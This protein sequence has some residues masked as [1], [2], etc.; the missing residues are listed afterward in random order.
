MTACAESVRLIWNVQAAPIAVGHVVP[1][2][3]AH[4]AVW[5]S[6]ETFYDLL[7]STVRSRS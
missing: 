3:A 5:R 7:L 4:I 2:V 6:R 1:V